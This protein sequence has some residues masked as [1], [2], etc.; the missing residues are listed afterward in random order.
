VFTFTEITAV[1]FTT[2][3]VAVT[4]NVVAV[5][6]EVGVPDTTPV[7]VLKLNPVGR[8]PPDIA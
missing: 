4:V 6:V 1:A 5:S 3:S 8:T 2:P 7:V